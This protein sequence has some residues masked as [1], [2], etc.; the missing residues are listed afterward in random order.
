MFSHKKTR[1]MWLRKVKAQKI[2]WATAWRRVNKKIKTDD[3][4]K[5]KKRRAQRVVRNIA[6]MTAEEITRKK[7]ET[8]D[9][10]ENQRQAALKEIK[11]RKARLAK[12]QGKSK[13]TKAKGK[14]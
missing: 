1:S 5:R 4:Q 2:K 3:T 9:V 7:M 14:K 12:A 6:G 10:R 11:D 13:A 8:P